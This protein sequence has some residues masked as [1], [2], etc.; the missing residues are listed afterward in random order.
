MKDLKT[1]GELMKKRVVQKAPAY[2]WQELALKI[3]KDFDVPNDK[4]GSIF[5]VCKQYN[6]QIV[7]RAMNDTK[8][9][10]KTGQK[11]NYFFKIIGKKSD[12]PKVKTE[13]LI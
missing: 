6:K 9:L 10:C 5:R 13:P 3:I 1:F 2:Q 11:W 4:R 8:E 12:A 7:E